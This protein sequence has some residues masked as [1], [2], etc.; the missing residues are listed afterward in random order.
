MDRII[1]DRYND[2]IFQE[3]LRRYAIPAEQVEALD[4]F[5]SFIYRFRQGD[6][7][8][9]LR[10]THSHRRTPELIRGE[11]DW[12]NYLAAGG[13]TVARA[14]ASASGQLVEEIDDGAG[15]RFLATAFAHAPGRPPWE[16]GWTAARREQY[17]R[18][19]GR[20]HAL[21]HSYAP[22]DPAWQRPAWPDESLPEVARHLPGRDDA[23]LARYRALVERV[24]ALP[25]DPEG[26]GLIHFDAHEANFHVDGE[27][28]TLFD[29][30]DC[31]YN[32]LV[33]DIA[34][35]IFYQATNRDDPEGHLTGFLPDFL[36]G[37]RAENRLDPAWLAAIP[38]FLTMREIELYAVIMRSYEV[39]PDE[40]GAIPHAW[41][42]RFMTGRRERIAAAMSYLAYDF[43]ALA[44]Q[45]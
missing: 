5:E 17:G 32:W 23:A 25:R 1:R 8:F 27:K 36:R 28:I 41:P 24:A 2:A 26:Y 3:V 44:E 16:M 10:V 39:G 33:N 18:L 9:I 43:E 12:I 4:G 38:D 11:V 7:S 42:R 31:G 19:I 20:M 34:M 22:R 37:Y 13:A 6:E 45:L 40:I 15:G 21:T 35:V 29:F 30:D 14:L